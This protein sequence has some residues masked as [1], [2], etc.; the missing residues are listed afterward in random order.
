MSLVG[1]GE[2]ASQMEG[3]MAKFLNSEPMRN[4]GGVAIQA[5]QS[6]ILSSAKAY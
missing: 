2:E 4:L 3:T 1:L 5:S 6:Q